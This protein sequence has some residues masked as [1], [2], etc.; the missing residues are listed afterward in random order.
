ME[1]EVKMTLDSISRKVKRIFHEKEIESAQKQ[2][3]VNDCLKAH[4]SRKVYGELYGNSSQ[5]QVGL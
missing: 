3:K 1:D 2:E 5:K 4:F